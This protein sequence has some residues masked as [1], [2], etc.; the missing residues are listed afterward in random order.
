LNN[1][2]KELK[3]Y[4]TFGVINLS[5]NEIES[6]FEANRFYYID[7][8]EEKLDIGDYSSASMLLGYLYGKKIIAQS[9]LDSLN[10]K[11]GIMKIQIQ[12]M[13][14]DHIPLLRESSLGKGVENHLE[15]KLDAFNIKSDL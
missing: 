13:F 12:D 4:I 7:K 15:E 1:L 3:D 9:V 6:K 14:E 8:K 5:S 2:G 11:L 10:E